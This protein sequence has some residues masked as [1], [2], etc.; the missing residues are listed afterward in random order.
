MQSWLKMCYSVCVCVC[1]HQDVSNVD[2]VVGVSSHGLTVLCGDNLLTSLNHFPWSVSSL[3][4]FPPPSL[5]LL[6]S[7]DTYFLCVACRVRI[8]A[9]NF[10]GK[11]LLLEMM[12]P[13][14]S[15][16]LQLSRYRLANYCCPTEPAIH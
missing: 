14:V 16:T 2:L 10:K 5:P 13:P 9:V 3:L 1:V 12:P 4:P 8:A 6:Q 15:K 7:S 11:Q